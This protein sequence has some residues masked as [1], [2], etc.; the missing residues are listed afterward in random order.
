MAYIYK[1]LK[2]NIL[3]KSQNLD[4]KKDIHRIWD[5]RIK[6]YLKIWNI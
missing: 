3:F 2:D 5:G 4:E 6:T 1:L